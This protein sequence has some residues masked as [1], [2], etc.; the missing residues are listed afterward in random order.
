MSNLARYPISD[1]HQRTRASAG[2]VLR[3]SRP[4]HD[5]GSPYS[6][7]SSSDVRFRHSSTSISEVAGAYQDEDDESIVD[8]SHDMPS[9]DEPSNHHRK[10]RRMSDVSEPRVAERRSVVET[11]PYAKLVSSP[12]RCWLTTPLETQPHHNA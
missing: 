9:E 8:F 2:P 11:D 1:P 6:T 7:I 10:R 3:L 12:Q 5:G 4:A